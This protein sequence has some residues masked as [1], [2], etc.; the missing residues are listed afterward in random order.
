ML[1]PQ[2]LQSELSTA[3]GHAPS[4]LPRPC[5]AAASDA[6]TFEAWLS[7]TD[8]C[9]PSAIFSYALDSKAEVSWTR[10]HRQLLCYPAALHAGGWGVG[11]A[12]ACAQWRQRTFFPDACDALTA[13]ALP[14]PASLLC[15]PSPSARPT[16]ITL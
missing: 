16:S 4:L 1:H 15:S 8:Y 9:H 2:L 14:K 10:V 13:A 5:P 12:G 6:F 3:G 7:T 11:D